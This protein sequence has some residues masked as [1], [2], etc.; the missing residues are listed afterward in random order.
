MDTV[1]GE[2]VDPGGGGVG[3]DVDDPDLLTVR[4]AELV[5]GIEVFGVVPPRGFAP[6]AVGGGLEEAAVV[7][8]PERVLR[9]RG[10]RLTASPAS[11]STSTVR[12]FSSRPRHPRHQ[13]GHTPD[14]RT[15]PSPAAPVPP[16][17]HPARNAAPTSTTASS[18]SPPAS[19]AGAD[20]PIQ[21]V[22]SS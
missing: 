19:S 10:D 1:D 22:R 6:R 21:C 20:S 17:G 3:A 4:G 11:P 14:R 5:S 9:G 7:V 13:P 2:V 8:D 16:P 18:P 15:N 12:P